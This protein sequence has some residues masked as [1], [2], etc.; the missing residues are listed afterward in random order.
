MIFKYAAQDYFKG[1]SSVLAIKHTLNCIYNVFIKYFIVLGH[2]RPFTRK[3]HT[4]IDEQKQ[5][6]Q[7]VNF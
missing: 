5:T 3:K 1:I 2:K 7:G 6:H 4:V